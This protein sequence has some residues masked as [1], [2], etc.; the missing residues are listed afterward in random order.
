M[1]IHGRGVGSPKNTLEIKV[2]RDKFT[3]NIA[4]TDI[5]DTHTIPHKL[6]VNDN[7]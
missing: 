2:T 7:N 4:H 3:N 1:F 6:D 5:I